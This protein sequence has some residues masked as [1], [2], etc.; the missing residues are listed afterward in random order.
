[1]FFLLELILII[2]ILTNPHLFHF[3]VALIGFI[4]LLVENWHCF[5]F[6]QLE[7]DTPSLVYV[8][9]TYSIVCVVLFVYNRQSS[10]NIK[11]DFGQ[12]LLTEHSFHALYNLGQTEAVLLE[13][14]N[15]LVFLPR[16]KVLDEVVAS[17]NLIQMSQ[18]LGLQNCLTCS[19]LYYFDNVSLL[20][21][22]VYAIISVSL[23]T[24]SKSFLDLIIIY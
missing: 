12:L 9:R 2:S 24:F 1:M 7:S 14:V 21:K 4:S 18:F 17:Y 23:G 10:A 13:N 20:V 11:E 15:S 3:A 22:L 8:V 16:S 6:C 5:Q 19:V